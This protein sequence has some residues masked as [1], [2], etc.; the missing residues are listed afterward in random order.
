LIGD[1]R[2]IEPLKALAATEQDEYVKN[3]V[4]SALRHLEK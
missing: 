2:A 3:K 1:P 4:E